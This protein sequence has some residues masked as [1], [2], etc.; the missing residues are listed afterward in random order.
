M[1]GA[2]ESSILAESTVAVEWQEDGAQLDTVVRNFKGRNLQILM[3]IFC[4]NG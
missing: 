1:V 4:T 2:R 3:L